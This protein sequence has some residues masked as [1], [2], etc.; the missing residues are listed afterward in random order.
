MQLKFQTNFNLNGELRVFSVAYVL[1]WIEQ[2][3]ISIKIK[4]N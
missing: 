1:G 2:V 3:S 4:P